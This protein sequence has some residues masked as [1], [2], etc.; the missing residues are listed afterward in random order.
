[1]DELQ[2]VDALAWVRSGAER[3]FPR[4]Q[5]D[6]LYLLAFA[7]ADVLE[8]GTGSCVVRRHPPGWWIIGSDDDWLASSNLPVGTLFQSVVSTPGRGQ[9]SMRSEVLVA[10]FA[11]SVWT[12]SSGGPLK[13]AG[14]DP[15]KGVWD[16]CADLRRAIVFEMQAP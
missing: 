7:M 8:L 15:A 16:K 4:G 10:A 5:V 2:P 13:I 11:K 1:M 3:F 9:H 12:T 14:D 6:P